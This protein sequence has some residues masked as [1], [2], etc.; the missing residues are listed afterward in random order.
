[1]RQ[2]APGK[3]RR[4]EPSTISAPKTMSLHDSPG[5]FTIF[6]KIRCLHLF[7]K[8]RAH[9]KKA[10]RKRQSRLRKTIFG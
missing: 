4:A 5:N 9:S 10:T 7:G 3:R 1:V 2:P 6:R 8:D